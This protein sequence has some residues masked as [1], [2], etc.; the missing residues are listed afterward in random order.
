MSINLWAQFKAILPGDPLLIGTVTALN[1]DGTS[2]IT[3]PGG[4]K[5]T[6]RG[7]GVA[8][9]SNAWIRAGKIESEAPTLPT[10]EIEI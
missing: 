8:L 5:L 1:N 7:S 10:V 4:A 6:V 3:L 9:G 2:R